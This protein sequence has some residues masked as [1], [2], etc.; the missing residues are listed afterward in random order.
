MIY[1]IVSHYDHV[2]FSP[3]TCFDWE[4]SKTKMGLSLKEIYPVGTLQ[5]RDFKEVRRGINNYI[6]DLERKVISYREY[7][8][9]SG[10]IKQ[11]KKFKPL[12]NRHVG[13][14]FTLFLQT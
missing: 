8:F 14:F 5:I 4:R 10:K 13:E 2:T 11:R 9:N 3:F 12:D 6:K 7:S 1:D